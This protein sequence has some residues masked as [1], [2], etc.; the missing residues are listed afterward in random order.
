MEA[1]ERLVAVRPVFMIDLERPREH[2]GPAKELLVE[3]VADTADRLSDQQ[4]GSR[5]VQERRDFGSRATEPPDA[6]ERAGGDSAPDPETALPHG[7]WSPPLVGDLA[8]TRDDEVQPTTD[9][10]GRNTPERD[11][12]NQFAIAAAP[13]PEAHRQRDGGDDPEDV[14]EPVYVDLQRADRES[15]A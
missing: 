10:A 1:R 12:G 7:Q 6:S 9:Q 11:V 14:H 3:V 8:P 15:V 4:S 2:G 13:L 5:A